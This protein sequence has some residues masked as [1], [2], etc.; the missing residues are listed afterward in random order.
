MG[1]YVINVVLVIGSLGMLLLT[2]VLVKAW[3]KRKTAD[4]LK[5]IA[6]VMKDVE[7]GKFDGGYSR[8]KVRGLER[9]MVK[10]RGLESRQSRALRI[11]FVLNIATTVLASILIAL[12]GYNTATNNQN[13]AL[14]LNFAA[15]ATLVVTKGGLF[16][17]TTVLLPA[18]KSVPAAV[19]GVII[20]K[21]VGEVMDE[22]K[23][24][25]KREAE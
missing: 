23:K 2:T 8:E 3:R 1:L 15:L 16:L 7:Q 25:K 18:V 24:K 5:A 13:L 6:A 17:L 11:G 10:V 20:S 14:T 9:H 12:A 19:T 21:K 4:V 22:R